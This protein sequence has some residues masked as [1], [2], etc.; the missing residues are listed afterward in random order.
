MVLPSVVISGCSCPVCSK[1]KQGEELRL[2]GR[3]ELDLIGKEFGLLKVVGYEADIKSRNWEC[4]CVC[5]N[6]VKVA[7]ADLLRGSRQ[8]CGC[9]KSF[10][11]HELG[12]IIRSW[13]VEVV[14]NTRKVI[15]PKEVDIWCPDKRIAIE[16][17]GLYWHGEARNGVEAR[18]KHRSKLNM[19]N[20]VGVRLI[21]IFEDEWVNRKDAVL[22]YLKSVLGV[23]GKSIG[24]R[25]CKLAED[26]DVR[27]FVEKNHILGCP[28]YELGYC[29]VYDGVIVAAMTFRHEH[30]RWNLSRFCVG[31]IGVIGAASRLLRAFLK[32]HTSE[33]VVSFS[34]KRWSA[35]DLYQKLGFSNDGEVAISYSYFIQGRPE[36][37]HKFE[38]RRDALLKRLGVEDCGQTEREL[39][40]ELGYDRIYDC[41]LDRWV[42]YPNLTTGGNNV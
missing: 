12:D 17:C 7:A 8:S 29:L 3:S 5:G 36:R 41:G 34:D 9:N 10:P 23:R 4:S 15:S 24:A 21:T 1:K 20:D 18:Q 6:M 26:V 28:K 40:I 22:N 38:F 19:C 42:L 31:E 13:G 25:E 14:T 2:R 35:G 39:A 30:K 33:P 11:Q 16:Y 32:T 27:E 37:H